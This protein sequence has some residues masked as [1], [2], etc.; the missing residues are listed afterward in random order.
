MNDN[1][2][3]GEEERGHV[4]TIPQEY[5]FAPLSFQILQAAQRRVERRLEEDETRNSGKG[6]GFF[7]AS[8]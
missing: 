4:R 8:L 5:F 7:I 3:T 2:D 6:L 1:E